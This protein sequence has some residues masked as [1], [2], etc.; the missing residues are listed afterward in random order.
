MA[1]MRNG[2]KVYTPNPN[3][4]P[5]PTQ[6]HLGDAEPGHHLIEAQHGALLRKRGKPCA[7][8]GRWW[9]VGG[10][11]RARAL[12]VGTASRVVSMGA[13]RSRPPVLAG[14]WP[15]ALGVAPHRVHPPHRAP[16][17][18]RAHAALRGHLLGVHATCAAEH[19]SALALRRTRPS[20]RT[21]TPHTPL[22]THSTR[23]PVRTQAARTSVHRSRRPCRNSWVGTMKPPLPTTGS[24]ITPATCSKPFIQTQSWWV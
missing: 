1:F 24:R 10:A 19:P 5:T 17:P 12:V 21:H 3:P 22:C 8:V 11:S 4:N 13:V 23:T 20:A 15:R 18:G 6:A 16:C 7:R 2:A 14:C 9:C